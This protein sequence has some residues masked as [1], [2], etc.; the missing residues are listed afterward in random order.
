MKDRAQ[1]SESRLRKS[2]LLSEPTVE[3]GPWAE[4]QKPDSHSVDL[5]D[6]SKSARG[7]GCEFKLPE[8]GVPS[9]AGDTVTQPRAK[10]LT[11]QFG[12]YLFKRFTDLQG[13]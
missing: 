4:P 11:Q 5:E 6:C 3:V 10:W 13:Q 1:H 8:S 2:I 7:E 9:D 12:Q